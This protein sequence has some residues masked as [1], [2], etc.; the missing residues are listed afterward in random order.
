MNC[1]HTERNAN[2]TGRAAGLQTWLCRAAAFEL[3]SMAFLPPS[4]EAA[5]SLVDGGYADACAEAFLGF[6]GADS[7][8]VD[9]ALQRLSRYAGADE[10]AIYHE[11]RCE[12]TR[13]FVGE[14]KPLVTPYV[15]V[16]AAEE[17]GRR[18]LLFLGEESMAIERFMRRCGVAKNLSLGQA[19]DPVDHIGTV[20]EFLKYLCL[21]NAQAVQVPEGFVVEESDCE[22]FVRDHFADYAAWCASRICEKSRT[23][24]YKAMASLLS[25]VCGANSFGSD[26]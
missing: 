7:A 9:R 25:S 10:D 1:E 15:G 13:L 8:A 18:G 4:H 17:R 11:L 12:Y 2:G 14:G 16:W 22:A 19:N 3:L 23:P 24:F 21:V 6:E 20:C 5:C 26:S